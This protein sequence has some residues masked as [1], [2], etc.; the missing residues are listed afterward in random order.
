MEKEE[1]AL[2]EKYLEKLEDDYGVTHDWNEV[3]IGMDEEG[4]EPDDS[5]LSQQGPAREEYTGTPGTVSA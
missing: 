1:R 3:S 4:D 2:I 5:S